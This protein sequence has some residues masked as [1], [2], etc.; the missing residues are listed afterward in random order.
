[1]SRLFEKLVVHYRVYLVA[2]CGAL[3]LAGSVLAAE[4]AG[5]PGLTIGI[6]VGGA[7]LLFI[8]ASWAA[9]DFERR[10]NR[11]SALMKAM[12]DSAENVEFDL[13]GQEDEFSAVARRVREVRGRLLATLSGASAKAGSLTVALNNLFAVTEQTQANARRQSEELEQVA[14]AMGQLSSAVEDVAGHAHRAADAAVKADTE[15]RKGLEVVKASQATIDELASEVAVTA[16]LIGSVKTNSLN[17]GTVLDV[18]RGIAEQTNLLALNAAIEAA[19][20]GEQ[21]RG[22]AVVADEV[23]SLAS[24]TQQSTQEI[25]DMIER[26]QSGANRAAEAMDHG[27]QRAE[28]TVQQ[29]RE[30]ADSLASIVEVVNSIR[31]MNVQIADV[32][33]EQSTT[34]GTITARL[35][36]ANQIAQETSASVAQISSSCDGL[37]TLARDLQ[38]AIG[39][40]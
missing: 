7:L 10:L 37:E 16:E 17:I 36:N 26:L 30:A 28:A 2:L 33:E 4:F 9:N 40:Y 32:A 31:R 21:G 5:K 6:A 38:S 20:A 22:F 1:M 27:R 29:A 15:S 12:G 11:F 34:S 8:V 24:R 23:R 19:R 35:G 3:G 18:I 13:G 14:S 39:E 25:Q